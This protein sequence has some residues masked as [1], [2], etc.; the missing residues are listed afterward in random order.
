M[1]AQYDTYHQKM[2][3]DPVVQ[4]YGSADPDFTDPETGDQHK[5]VYLE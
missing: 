4:D 5:F 1:Y 3:P 2:D